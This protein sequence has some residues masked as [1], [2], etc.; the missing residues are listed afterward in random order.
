M[1]EIISSDDDDEATV[2][3][4]VADLCE[5]FAQIDV[6]GDGTMEW[7]EFTGFLVE[8]AAAVD[9]AGITALYTHLETLPLQEPSAKL[10]VQCVK[11]SEERR[12]GKECVSTCRSR[13]S[14]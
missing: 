2:M 3:Q 4:T 1:L 7:E 12:V 6:N 8:Q 13:W 14:L 10:T 5:L 11:R 9:T